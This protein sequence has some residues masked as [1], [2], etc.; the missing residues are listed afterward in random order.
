M[1]EK[2]CKVSKSMQNLKKCSKALILFKTCVETCRLYQESINF[3][4]SAVLSSVTN[5]VCFTD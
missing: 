3:S 1:F 2:V 5:T 4:C